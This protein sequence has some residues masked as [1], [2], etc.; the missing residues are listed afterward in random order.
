MRYPWEHPESD[1]VAALQRDLAYVV[2]HTAVQV[3]SAH[4]GLC[5]LVNTPRGQVMPRGAC[6]LSDGSA[7]EFQ[8]VGAPQ[9]GAPE[10]HID[11]LVLA[12]WNMIRDMNLEIQ[13]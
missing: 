5:L 8:D 13:S 3:R 7:I 11:A 1:H 6:T 4:A 10:M 12:L 9:V 2:T